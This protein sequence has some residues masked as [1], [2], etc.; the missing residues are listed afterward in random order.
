M[1]KNILLLGF[2]IP[3]DAA[4][5]LFNLDPLPSI[6]TH[7]FAWSFTNALNKTKNNVRL[8]SCSPVQSYPL[9]NKIIFRR[10]E[11]FGPKNVEGIH[12]AFINFPVLKHITRFLACLNST[13][14]ILL[15]WKIDT[16][17]IHGVHSPYLVYG[18][19][20]RAAG[21]KVVVIITDPPGVL[22]SSDNLISI[23][24]KKLDRFIVHMCLRNFDGIISLSPKLLSKT[25]NRQKTLTFPGIL[26]ESWLSIVESNSEY[27]YSNTFTVCYAGSLVKSYGVTNLLQAAK[28]MPNV[29][30]IFCGKGELLECL[31]KCG[32]DNVIVKG[33]LNSNDL[34]K[35]MLGVDILINPRPV[36]ADF[37]MESFPSKLIEYLA[38]GRP[39]ITTKIESIP[40]ELSN[41]FLYINGEDD[42][43][44]VEAIEHAFLQTRQSLS[45]LG[46]AGKKN[47]IK[48]YS[49]D[50]IAFKLDRY[51]ESLYS[52]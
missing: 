23:F 27:R 42:Q 18:L 8:L 7:K 30:F 35:I 21:L 5:V 36:S 49:I 13:P 34:A 12:L 45:A 44:I 33:F 3:D 32:L 25:D 48:N 29:L 15:R 39:V 50:A 41:Y 46:A 1:K 4:N 17:F 52:H 22:I 16:I 20:L 19:L 26:S 38:T 10:Y 43:C 11:F 2:T 6:Q 47:V 51:I 40:E 28:K 31:S 14:Y 9:V 37:S 24:L